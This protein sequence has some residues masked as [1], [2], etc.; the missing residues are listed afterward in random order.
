[1]SLAVAAGGLAAAAWPEDTASVIN[2]VSGEAKPTATAP[3]TTAG[4]AEPEPEPADCRDIR[5]ISQEA[6]IGAVVMVMAEPTELDELRGAMV[7][8]LISNYTL[9]TDVTKLSDQVS[10]AGQTLQIDAAMNALKDDTRNRTGVPVTVFLDEEGGLVQQ[11]KT[12]G[13]LGISPLPSAHDQVASGMTPEQIQ[14]LYFEHGQKLSAIGVDVVLGPV[15]DIAY[16]GS[17]IDDYERAYGTYGVDTW[18]DVAAR[19]GAVV[20]GLRA[21]GVQAVE[22]HFAYGSVM[23]NTH[24]AP[25][26][27]ANFDQLQQDEIPVIQQL[28]NVNHVSGVM[29][30]LADMPGLT[31]QVGS[32]ENLPAALSSAPYDYLK[33]LGFLGSDLTDALDMDALQISQGKPDE[34]TT[35]RDNAWAAVEAGADLV[36][37]DLQAQGPVVEE[38]KARLADGS[39][40]Q[41]RFDEAAAV[42][43]EVY[44]GIQICGYDTLADMTADL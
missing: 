38:F 1:M 10:L 26:R 21:A 37:I 9:R 14:Q 41:D 27:T 3:P 32:N 8:N 15:G 31:S 11:T 28:I 33:Q 18:Q 30:S 4:E 20:E 39:L 6:K 19:T 22:K 40:S 7:G 35:Q 23:D 29:V 16:P 5:G 12:L 42:N 17:D 24:D 44:K 43:F 13:I 34:I 36:I 2:R 25:G